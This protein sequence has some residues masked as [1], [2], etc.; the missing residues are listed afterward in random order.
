MAFV[1][2][3]DGR[4]I[5]DD[6]AFST[7]VAD[8]EATQELDLH[9]VTVLSNSGHKWVAGLDGGQVSLAGPADDSA[10]TGGQDETLD[11]ARG[12]T[13]GEPVSVAPAGFTVGNRVFFC[14][15]RTVNYAT[16]GSVTDAVRYQAQVIADGLLDRGIS[17][18][19]LEAETATGN[20]TSQDNSASSSNGGA[21]VLHVTAASG[22]SPTLDA[23]VQHSS[24]NATWVDLVTFTQATATTSER[25]TVTGTVNRYVRAEWTIGGTGPSF[26][27]AIAFARR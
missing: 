19:D 18:H 15:G 6:V 26:T 20:D 16:S 5:V 11:S 13:N 1:A 14:K 9:D 8:W 23:T 3:K 27:F 25:S 22:T 2:G 4:V 10:S 21:A 24:D 12:S 17:L 7:Y